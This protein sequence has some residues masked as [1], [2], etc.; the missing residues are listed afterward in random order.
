MT[1]KQVKLCPCGSGLNYADCCQPYHLYQTWPATAEQLMRSRFVAFALG[2]ESYLQTTWAK[3]TRLGSLDLED[4]LV[5]NRLEIIATEQGM[6]F[7]DT[8]KVHFKAHY[9]LKEGGK[10]LESGV[11]EEVSQFIRDENQH[12]VYLTG[13][14]KS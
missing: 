3:S 13:D 2:L 12:W 4:N 14:V 6:P 9:Q 1:D 5:W 8:G 10:V 7:D 11:M